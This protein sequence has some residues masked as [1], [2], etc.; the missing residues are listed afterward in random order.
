M[1][2]IRSLIF[3]ILGYGIIAMGCICNS[4]IGLFNRKLTMK[5]WNYVFLPSFAWTLQHIAGIKIEVRGKQYINQEKGIYAG[6]HQSAVETY[7]LTNF[8]KRHKLQRMRRK[9]NSNTPAGRLL[10]AKPIILMRTA[11]K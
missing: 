5:S 8:I 10:T 11:I 7:L 1:L 4:I 2:F 9:V 6:K 3:N